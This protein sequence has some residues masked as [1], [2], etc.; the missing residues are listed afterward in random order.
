MFFFLKRWRPEYRDRLGVDLDVVHAE[1]EELM[2]QL[3][4]DPKR[5]FRSFGTGNA[6]ELKLLEA[7]DDDNNKSN[8]NK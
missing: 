3:G 5:P 4:I 2:Q 7:A 8:D 1:I 6:P